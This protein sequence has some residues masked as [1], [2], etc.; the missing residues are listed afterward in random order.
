MIIPFTVFLP[1]ALLVS[2]ASIVMNAL[3][4]REQVRKRLSQAQPSIP[5]EEAPQG[6]GPRPCQPRPDGPSAAGARRPLFSQMVQRY[7]LHEAQEKR[8]ERA[9]TNDIELRH[10]G[11]SMLLLLVEDVP[12]FV[13]KTI[14][15]A[16]C[17]KRTTSP[18][19]HRRSFARRDTTRAP[20]FSSS[21]IP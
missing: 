4:L 20:T 5:H 14:L 9:L 11:M 2:V 13:M 15:C 7:V 18:L 6:S 16:R 17:T 3:L 12:F 1:L 8:K 21:S 10:F 19:L